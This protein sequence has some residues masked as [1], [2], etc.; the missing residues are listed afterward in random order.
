MK[1]KRFW[2]DRK[3]A[4]NF[5]AELTLV[6]LQVSIIT[7][8]RSYSFQS[9]CVYVHCLVVWLCLWE[10]SER[11]TITFIFSLVQQRWVCL[12]NLDPTGPPVPHP[13][14]PLLLRTGFPE[15]P[16][17]LQPLRVPPLHPHSP[18]LPPQTEK[19]RPRLLGV[20]ETGTKQVWSHEEDVHAES[21]PTSQFQWGCGR[22]HKKGRGIG[23]QRAH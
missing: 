17:L 15:C 18:H 16:C 7:I 2:I 20:A 1:Y 9:L 5:Y 8:P 14:G 6:F 11:A 10:V 3:K 4:V 12:L 23:W 21:R 19:Q 13:G 22:P